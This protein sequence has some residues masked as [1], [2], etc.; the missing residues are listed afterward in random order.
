MTKERRKEIKETFKA[1]EEMFLQPGFV[2][3]MVKAFEFMNLLAKAKD[4]LHLLDE[5]LEIPRDEDFR[6]D[7]AKVVE[8]IENCQSEIRQGR[9]G[10]EWLKTAMERIR[11]VNER[12]KDW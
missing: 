1:L 12:L 2:E 6:F 10:D 5:K 3:N 4:C 7:I 11:G 8:A 9:D